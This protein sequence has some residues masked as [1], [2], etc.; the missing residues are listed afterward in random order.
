V[1][2]MTSRTTKSAVLSVALAVACLVGGVSSSTRVRAATVSGDKASMELLSSLRVEPEYRGKYNRSRFPH[3]NKLANGCFVREQVLRDESRQPAVMSGRFCNVRSGV[4]LSAY[5]NKQITNP[6][7][8]EIDH[9]VALSE[10]WDSGAWKWD[11]RTRE[12]FAND[13]SLPHTLRAVSSASNREKSDKDP[14]EWLPVKSFQCQYAAEWVA[15]KAR[16]KL[17]VD[18]AERLKLHLL[19]GRC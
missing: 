6:A 15:V 8:I 17:S 1:R 9:V 19:L 4:W 7:M 18:P 2:C 11:A 16:W 13:I 3:W 5:D 14:A 10:A 12:L